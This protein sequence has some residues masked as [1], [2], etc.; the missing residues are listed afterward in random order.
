M[1]INSAVEKLNAL[2]QETRLNIFRVL[3]QSGPKGAPV[4]HIKERLGVPDATLSFH[5]TTLK[6]AGLIH[7]QRQG[8]QLF[9]SADYSAMKG[10]VQYLMEDCCAKPAKKEAKAETAN[11]E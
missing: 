2:A 10:L 7:R 5:L 1:E 3:I 11:T 8:R 4:A 6:T 9:Y